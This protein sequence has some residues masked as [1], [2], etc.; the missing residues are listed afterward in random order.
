MHI[1]TKQQSLSRI[2]LAFGIGLTFFGILRVSVLPI[3]AP[4]PQP[5]RQDLLVEL[6]SQG[7]RVSSKVPADNRKDVSNAEG[8]RLM[9]GNSYDDGSIHG[10][11]T[12][13]GVEISLTPIRTRSAELLS[14]DTIDRAINKRDIKN[15][16]S[17]RIGDDLFLRFKYDNRAQVASSCIAGGQA[18][19]LKDQVKQKAG[20]QARSWRDRIKTTIGVEPL[21]DWSCLFITI[22]VDNNQSIPK[23][24]EVD[25]EIRRV[26]ARLKPIF[27]ESWESERVR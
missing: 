24:S 4:P 5:M 9:H 18:S 7:W 21:T 13:K 16:R 12:Q 14:S 1:M 11:I 23:I 2:A 15:K 17:L 10:E 25:Q 8:V 6:Q 20:R 27:R 3:N 26:W 19:S 22:S